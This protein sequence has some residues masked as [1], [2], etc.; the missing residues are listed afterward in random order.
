MLGG[1]EAAEFAHCLSTLID[2]PSVD[3]FLPILVPQSLVNPASV[4][5][6]IVDQSTQTDK[7]I[8]VCM[9]GEQSVKEARQI[10]HKNHV[11][12]V[13]FPEVP[14]NVLGAMA[15]YR[16]WLSKARQTPFV[17]YFSVKPEAVEQLLAKTNKQVLGEADTRPILSDYGFTPIAGGVAQNAVSG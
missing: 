4:A 2:D 16:D 10:L 17:V 12:M 5:Q 9:V 11:P 1:A 15:H 6:A 8:I 14:G 13:V 3:A 7:T